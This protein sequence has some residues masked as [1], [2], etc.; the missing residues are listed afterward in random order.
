MKIEV[1]KLQV[2]KRFTTLVTDRPGIVLEKPARSSPDRAGYM[3]GVPCSFGATVEFPTLETKS[4][5]P[6]I[7]VWVE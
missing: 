7:K 5:H 2:G 4:I 1:G 6:Q 3:D